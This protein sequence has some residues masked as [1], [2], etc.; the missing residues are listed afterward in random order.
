MALD[1]LDWNELSRSITLR[2]IS[3]HFKLSFK[4]RKMFISVGLKFIE[5]IANGFDINFERDSH[6]YFVNG[7]FIGF[8]AGVFHILNLQ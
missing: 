6:S 8:L 1:S 3:K 2:M 7:Q 5:S 4:Q